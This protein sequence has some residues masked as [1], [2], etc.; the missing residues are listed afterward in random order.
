MI[1]E[2]HHGIVIRCIVRE[3]DR[4]D[5]D[6]ILQQLKAKSVV[7]YFELIYTS[8]KSIPDKKDG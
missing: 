2:I 4:Q 5:I 8:L 1:T 7:P 6:L 3:S